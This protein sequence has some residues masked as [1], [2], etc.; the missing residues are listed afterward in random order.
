MSKC[1]TCGSG[2]VDTPRD[3]DATYTVQKAKEFLEKCGYRVSRSDLH[4]HE[5]LTGDG[6]IDQMLWDCISTLETK[7]S[8]YTVGSADRLA[9]FRG[10]GSDAGI[11]MEQAWYVFWNKH[12]RAIASYVKNGEVKSNESIES[13][14]MDCVVYLL[15]FTKMVREKGRT[16]HGVIT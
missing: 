2:F 15:L 9:N 14:I 16:D 6:D 1:E 11:R 8:E 13:R 4:L 12:V 3:S 7:G 10:A 5:E